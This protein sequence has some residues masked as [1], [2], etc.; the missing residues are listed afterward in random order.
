MTAPFPDPDQTPYEKNLQGD[1]LLKQK[2]RAVI[3]LKRLETGTA[4]IAKLAK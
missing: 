2:Q 4:G 1:G 3:G